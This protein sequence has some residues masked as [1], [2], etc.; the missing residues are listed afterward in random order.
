MLYQTLYLRIEIIL[1]FLKKIINLFSYSH[2][3]IRLVFNT[4]CEDEEVF[5]G[6]ALYIYKC[7]ETRKL[8]LSNNH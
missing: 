8:F 7:I 4:T 1:L 3:K 2:V 5:R 6:V